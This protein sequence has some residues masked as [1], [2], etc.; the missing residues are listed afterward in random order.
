MPITQAVL[1]NVGHDARTCGSLSS[2]FYAVRTIGPVF[3]T[4]FE[5]EE[6]E[7]GPAVMPRRPCVESSL[8][9]PSYRRKTNS[10][11]DAF[12]VP[13]ETATVVGVDSF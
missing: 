11:G 9:S 2:A 3:R 12:D 8:F 6:E 10:T 7:E 1:G 5:E 4:F 13:S